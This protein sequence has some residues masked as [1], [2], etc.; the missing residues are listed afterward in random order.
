MAGVDWRIAGLVA[1]RAVAE[2]ARPAIRGAVE[3]GVRSMIPVG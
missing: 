2:I 1:D 3:E